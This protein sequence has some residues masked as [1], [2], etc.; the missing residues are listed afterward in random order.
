MIL[1]FKQVWNKL[2][3]LKCAVHSPSIVG[4]TIALWNLLGTCF[5]RR[6]CVRIYFACRK[7]LSSLLKEATINVFNA[8]S[9]VRCPKLSLKNKPNRCSWILV[10]G[11]IYLNRRWY[12]F[13][14]LL[15]ICFVQN[16]QTKNVFSF[17]PT[18]LPVSTT[19]KSPKPALTCWIIL[20]GT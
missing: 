1:R 5:V 16:A 10:K 8:P 7:R 12:Q 19:V 9:R 4:M 14:M 11:F 17:R 2:E 6:Q 3:Q 20:L 18:K 13:E 15:E